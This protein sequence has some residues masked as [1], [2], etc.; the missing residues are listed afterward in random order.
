MI[1]AQFLGTTVLSDAFSVAFMIPN[2]FRRLFAEGSIA[3]AF[4]PTFKQYLNTNDK[5]HIA[6]FLSSFITVLTVLV[7]VVVGSGILA[8]P[9]IVPLFG[10]EAYEETVLL[11]RLMFPFLA[12]ISCAAFFQGILNSIYIFAP[13]GF[14]PIVLNIVTILCA[15]I[16]SP[17]MANPARALA[18]GIL[19]GGFLEAA[20]QI[21]FVLKAGYL[22]SCINL[23]K[24][25]KNPGV[26]RVIHLIIPTI[27]GM[28]A[29]QL[30]D[31]ISTVLAG[32]AGIG[33]V[34][35]LQYSLRLQELILGVF[36]VSLGTVLLPELADYAQNGDWQHYSVQLASALRTIVLITVPIS[37]F[38]FACGEE[39]IRL[40][41]QKQSFDNDSV[42]LTLGAFNFHIPGI[43]FIA[44]NRIVTPAL[45]AQGDTRSPTIAGIISLLVNMIVAVLLAGHFKGKGIAFALSFASAVNTVI[46]FLLLKRKSVISLNS[47]IKS[48]VL[49]S[50]KIALF[51]GIAI[52]PVLIFKTAAAPSLS[53]LHKILRY[54]IPVSI[55]ALVCAVIGIFLLFITKDKH[56]RALVRSMRKEDSSPRRSSKDGK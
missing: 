51:S 1:K 7:T 5:N 3:V 34:S 29:Y 20:I 49:Y 33:V 55:G 9:I 56:V 47:I 48:T 35:S 30:N 38:S 43:V 40:L 27:I 19:I 10:L 53:S 6:T 41:F 4:I 28:A 37:V 22:C 17:F 11:T 2:L 26:K 36:A 15:Y 45:Y 18:V 46:L 52:I 50:L 44:I 23:R 14:A 32:N 21:P 8:A 31:L 16:L 54:G 39:L 12:F 24:A 13:S 42:L 25:I